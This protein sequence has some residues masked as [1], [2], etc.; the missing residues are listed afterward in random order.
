M[1]TKTSVN[2]V[3]KSVT[4]CALLCAEHEDFAGCEARA[5]A[6]AAKAKGWRKRNW[7]RLAEACAAHD[8]ARVAELG[9]WK[10]HAEAN[11]PTK[12]AA[13]PKAKAEPK[14]PVEKAELAEAAYTILRELGS[15]FGIVAYKRAPKS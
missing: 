14:A 10:T 8:L 1:S 6:M 7:T 11:A 3:G 15:E 2:Y 12:A 9:S 4:E 5:K 13:K